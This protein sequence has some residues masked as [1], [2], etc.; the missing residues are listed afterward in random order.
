MKTVEEIIQLIESNGLSHSDLNEIHR[1]IISLESEER[2]KVLTLET[3]LNQQDIS[4]IDRDRVKQEIYLTYLKGLNDAAFDLAYKNPPSKKEYHFIRQI[5][6]Y[7]VIRLIDNYKEFCP[8]ELPA[9]SLESIKEDIQRLKGDREL[10][11]KQRLNSRWKDKPY[12]G[13]TFYLNG[14]FNMDSKKIEFYIG[15]L[16]FE[17]PKLGTQADYVI[18]GGR[19][20]K[21]VKKRKQ[22]G[23]QKLTEQELKAIIHKELMEYV[24]TL[25]KYYVRNNPLMKLDKLHLDR[26]RRLLN[27]FYLND[28][29]KTYVIEEIK[30]LI[31][32]VYTQNNLGHK[33]VKIK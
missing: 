8:V 14:Q 29:M 31:P 6:M 25:V 18:I 11:T 9:E 20:T 24:P 33:W 2:L 21:R 23:K 19:R 1:D 27:S 30:K 15:Q 28:N 13:K 12:N 26:S 16:G 3:K 17:K 10:F 32:E 22:L 7:G 4:E 5:T